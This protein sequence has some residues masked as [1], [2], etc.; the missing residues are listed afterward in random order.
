MSTGGSG[1]LSLL[2]KYILELQQQDKSIS[3]I[4][5]KALQQLLLPAF[6]KLF[7]LTVVSI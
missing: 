2:Q 7:Q 1:F 5:I 4:E 6:R 3:L